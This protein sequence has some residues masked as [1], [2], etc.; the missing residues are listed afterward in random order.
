MTQKSEVLGFLT[1]LFVR[2]TAYTEVEITCTVIP[3]PYIAA[4]Q[5]NLS[6][7]ERQGPDFFFFL[8]TGTSSL[9]SPDCKCFSLMAG[10]RYAH[11]PFMTGFTVF[12][13]HLLVLLL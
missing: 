3:F 6:T 5:R 9:D 10:F 13:R 12:D 7:T 8:L 2:C 11:V 4:V 1:Y